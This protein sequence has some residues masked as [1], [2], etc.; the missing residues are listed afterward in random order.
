MRY[1][2]SPIPPSDDAALLLPLSERKTLA[3]LTDELE[4]LAEAQIEG[5]DI[6]QQLNALLRAASPRLRQAIR[7]R[8]DA[9]LEQIR[10]ELQVD[11]VMTP[12]QQ[13]RL[14]FLK[15]RENSEMR[16]TLGR[17]SLRKLRALF[18]QHPTLIHIVFGAGSALKHYGVTGVDAPQATP[19]QSQVPVAIDKASDKNI[20]R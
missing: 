14:A 11:Q 10:E 8:F 2:N 5:E 4:A 18:M 9:I 19:E 20:T 16:R 6:Q 15:T 1:M 3:L 17:A 13:Q 12:G 7:K